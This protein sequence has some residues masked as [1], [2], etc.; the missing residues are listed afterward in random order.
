MEK[1]SP[2]RGEGDQQ[3]F[4]AIRDLGP[5][6]LFDFF[7]QCS[8]LMP[9]DVRY[10]LRRVVSSAGTS[11][12]G[13]QRAL[14]VVRAQWTGLRTGEAVKLAVVGPA[15]TGKSSLIA[16][17]GEGNVERIASV[18]TVVDLQGLEEYLGYGRSE[19]TYG[20][21]E[22]A[23]LLL[24]VLDGSAGFTPDTVG[25]VRRF[26]AM[27]KPLLVVLNK[28]DLVE[29]PRRAV[30]EAKALL[31][32]SVIPVAAY[33]PESVQ[34]LLRAIVAACP[35]A[36]YPLAESLPSFRRSIC[37]GIVSQAAFGSGLIGAL[38]IPVADVL[39]ISAIQVA[40]LL[41]LAR[42]HGFTIGRGRARELVP[43]LASGL[44]VR[45]GGHRL[46][47]MFPERS[48]LISISVG[49]LWTYLVGLAAVRYF[50]RLAA[51]VEADA[52]MP[53]EG[54]RQPGNEAQ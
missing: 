39:P 4:R 11:S 43:L 36:L 31:R 10:R 16:A 18:F 32:V 30:A 14:E 25:L 45:E 42:A 20:E 15:R 46:K 27:D 6:E 22:P 41:K 48:T 52:G 50:E 51:L 9:E 3:V 34:R 21:V 35:K 19:L 47:E 38:P 29:K 12:D 44:L 23:D 2:D 24:V 40:M 8:L 37:G 26:T 1:T 13:L 54:S 33:R 28:M 17:I 7:E 49:G 53:A 5:G